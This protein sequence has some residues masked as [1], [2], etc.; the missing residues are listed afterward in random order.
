[1]A[2]SQKG[3]VSKKRLVTNILKTKGPRRDT[4][5]EHQGNRPEPDREE[6]MGRQDRKDGGQGLGW[7]GPGKMGAGLPPWPAHRLPVPP[8]GSCP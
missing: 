1:M 8:P 3:S 7:G 6:V 4:Q 2:D 5:A